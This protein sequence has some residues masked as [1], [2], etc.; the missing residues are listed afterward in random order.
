MSRC[1]NI[2]WLEVY[3]LEVVNTPHN[4]D[5]FKRQGYNV[6]VRN[7]GTPQYQQMFTIMGD[8]GFPF[9]EVR[10]DPYSLRSQGGIFPPNACHIRLSNRACYARNPI[11]DL[12]KFLLLHNYNYQSL[13][14]IDICLDFN[15]FDTGETPESFIRK[16]MREEISKINQSAFYQFGK[17]ISNIY[18]HGRD[19]WSTRIINS[20]KWGT[21]KSSIT[22]KLY[23]KSLEMEQVKRKFY[24]QDAWKA[25]DLD[26][27]KDIW[28]VE[29]SLN[30]S[31]K[32]LESKDKTYNSGQQAERDLHNLCN[33]DSREKLLRYFHILSSKYF[34]FKNREL[35]A[36]GNVKPK[37]RCSDHV[38][39]K[40]SP[41]EQIYYPKRLTYQTEPTRTDKM[42]IKKLLGI[43]EDERIDHLTRTSAQ[44]VIT[45]L[46][47]EK[48]MIEYQYQPHLILYSD[49]QNPQ[50]KQDIW[51]IIP[52]YA[53][54]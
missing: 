44:D 15:T 37:N 38:C 8:D 29:F 12:R 52:Q 16:Y 54:F 17:D 28:R 41:D 19:A 7:Y 1:V 25:A 11:Q 3:C 14:R 34:H 40:T 36:S 9:V 20:I 53:P 2:D 13:S 22:T 43:V 33:Y 31:F 51:G 26:L 10:R 50:R 46:I 6:N 39:F 47:N 49:K 5:Y 18:F 32:M 24:I 30:S 45:Y 27:S 23:N 21:D 42:L 48:R 4:A 35:T